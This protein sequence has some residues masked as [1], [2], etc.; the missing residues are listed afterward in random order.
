[1][2]KA[3]DVTRCTCGDLPTVEL[4]I[5]DRFWSCVMR[6]EGDDCNNSTLVS[7]R[8]PIP[9]NTHSRPMLLRQADKAVAAASTQWNEQALELS[10]VVTLND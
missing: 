6:C 4:D 8:H 2:S 5:L 3:P 1:M 9:P 10:K 7:I